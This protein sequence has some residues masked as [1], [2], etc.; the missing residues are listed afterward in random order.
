M[1]QQKE[2]KK[3]EEKGRESMMG[4]IVQQGGTVNTKGGI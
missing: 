1:E 3:C 2:K 4:G